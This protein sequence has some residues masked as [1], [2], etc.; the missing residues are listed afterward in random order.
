MLNGSKLIQILF[1]HPAL[2][3]AAVGVSFIDVATGEPIFSANGQQFFYPASVQKAI[4]IGSALQLLGNEFRFQTQVFYTG[5]IESGVLQGNL[6]IE[7]QGD[8][9]FNSRFFSNDFLS[10]INDKLK[11]LNIQKI[12]GKVVLKSKNAYH[13]TVATWLYEDIANYFGSGA[14]LFNYKDNMY[15]ITFQQK[16]DGLSPSILSIEP[17]IPYNF[18][19]LLTCSGTKKGDNAFIMGAP[20][21]K[22]REVVGTIPAGTAKFIVKGA[23]SHPLE[24]FILDLE[25]TISIQNQEIQSSEEVLILNFQSPKLSDLV[26]VTNHESV[27]LFAESLFNF[28]GFHFQQSFTNEAG[29]AVLETFVA[30]RKLD[31]K[32]IRIF[33]GSGLSRLNAMTPN[34]AA[35]WFCDF[36][37]NKDFVASL[38]VAGVSGTLKSLN[39][40]GI[41]S[42]VMAK[43]GSAEGVVNYAGYINTNSGK[44]YAFSIF[45]NQ[46]YQS[47]T[48]IKREIGIF[49][50]SFI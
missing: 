5:K 37:S 9:T 18:D 46:A 14:Q 48:A 3:G 35:T 36:Y 45:V 6:V 24:S 44:T 4:T 33:D 16:S 38:P 34:F 25:K 10:K 12:Q 22:E 20:F 7:A 31:V 1:R 26:K 15:S 17:K 43:S 39:Q 11:E 29:I 13:N 21:S 19:L 27:N 42:K 47:R 32:Q 50:E 49:L 2:Q 28:L 40:S 23:N 41:V 8:P 30:Q